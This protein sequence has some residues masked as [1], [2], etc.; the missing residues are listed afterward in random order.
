MYGIKVINKRVL[1]RDHVEHNYVQISEQQYEKSLCREKQQHTNEHR[2]LI[3]TIKILSNVIEGSDT[4]RMMYDTW[5]AK[6]TMVHN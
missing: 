6:V 1:T 5:E 3:L 4:S 2:I